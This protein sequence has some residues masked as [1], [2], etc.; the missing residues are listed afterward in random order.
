[1][2]MSPFDI[3]PKS[4]TKGCPLFLP[5]RGDKSQTLEKRAALPILLAGLRPRESP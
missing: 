3:G 5:E 4:E 1:M 2:S